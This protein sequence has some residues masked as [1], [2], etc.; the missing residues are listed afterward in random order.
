MSVLSDSIELFIKELMEQSSEVSLQRNELAQYFA[1][2]PSQINYVL[3]T[4]FTLDHGYLTISR[5]GSGGY[6]RVVRVECDRNNI[7]HDMACN[8]VGEQ[9][10]KSD[11]YAMVNRL[12]EENLISEREGALMKAAL[13]TSSMPTQELQDSARAQMM[14]SLLS[15]FMQDAVK[16]E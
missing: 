2:A 12:Q 7:V 3:S 15:I 16:E 6:I 10:S 1:C 4:R 13:K 14:R 11:A 5:R 8:R 9:L